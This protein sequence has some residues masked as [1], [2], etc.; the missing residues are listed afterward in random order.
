MP[1]SARTTSRVRVYRYVKDGIISHTFRPGDVIPERWL[2][3]TLGVSRTPVRE[4]LQALQGEGWLTV[5]PRKGTVV[6]ELKRVEVEEM[7]Q[8]RMIISSACIR[9][10]VDRVGP[11]DLAYFET[12]LLR[13]EEAAEEE[14]AVAFMAADMALHL[15]IVRLAG[16]RRLLAFTQ[17]L[18][19]TFQR[20][21]IQALIRK[22]RYQECISEHRAVV[23]ALAR[24]DAR[25]AAESMLEHLA[26][27][28]DALWPDAAGKGITRLF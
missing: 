25:A 17:D 6:R 21:G 12:L 5:V 26:S 2:A 27:T 14:N 19:D 16:N 7:L 28:R 10:G 18:C 9:L 1:E 3:E 13:Q 20:M 4:A 24:G 15:G 8:L 11:S 23:E 22:K